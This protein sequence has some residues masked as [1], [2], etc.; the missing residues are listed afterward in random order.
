VKSLKDEEGIMEERMAREYEEVD[1]YDYLRVL[2]RWKWLILIGVVVLTLTAIPAAYLVRKYESQGVLRFAKISLPTY[3]VYSAVFNDPH[4]FLRYLKAHRIITG[5][6]LKEVEGILRTKTELDDH[7]K[8]IY[9]FSEKETRAFEPKEQFIQGVQISWEG[10]SPKMASKMVE[11]L[12]LFVKDAVEQKMLEMYV[13]ETHKELYR[14]VNELES[15]LADLK[16]SLSQNERK[17]RDIKRIAREFPQAEGTAGREVV[18]VEKG[19]H[20]YLPPST[21]M[22]ATQ[23]AISEDR[24]NI[25]DTE[26]QLKINRLKLELF[27]AFKGALG[28]EASIGGLFERLKKVRDDFF[29]DK[30]LSRDEVLIVRNEVYSDF[31]RFEHLFRDVIRFISGPTMP[32][33]AKPSPK[34]VAAIAFVLALFFFVLLAF[35]LEFIQRGRKREEAPQL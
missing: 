18:W 17:L 12:G 6:E 31:A 11:A 33:K 7:I 19:G 35:F 10:A 5:N 25:R 14:M 29:K 3:K 22:V 4:L 27:Q 24:L 34:M 26:R 2:W 1:L 9:A 28:D 30:D 15:K 16:F 21:Q 13:T 20:R 23:V 8:P 32:G